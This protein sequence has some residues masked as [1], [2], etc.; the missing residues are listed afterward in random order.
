MH[1]WEMPERSF[2]AER[3]AVIF[4]IALFAVLASVLAWS[5]YQS[6]Q[7]AILRINE[8]VTTSSQIVA[9]N[10]GWI[11]AL[12]WQALRRIDDRLGPEVR[13]GAA[14][15]VEDIKDAVYG[16]P[17]QV[18]AYVVNPDGMTLY[19]TD[20]QLKPIDIRDREYFS[21]L[22]EGASEYISPLLV[23]RLNG[24]QIFVF[25][26]RLQRGGKFAGAA[27]VSFSADML[28]SIWELLDLGPGST[29]SIMRADGQLVARYPKPPGPIDLSQYI[30]FTD[31]LKKSDQGVYEAISPADGARRIVSYR[32]V[33]GTDLVVQ[34]SAGFEENMREFWRNLYF[35]VS[36]AAATAIGL[37][38]GAA[39]IASLLKRDAVRSRALERAL[40][41]NQMLM[42]E[43]HHRV[44]NNLQII[45]SLIRLQP[46]PDGVK[47]GLFDRLSAMSSVHEHIY[48]YDRF[49]EISAD[50]LIPGV[51][52]PLI[53]AYRPDVTVDYDLDACPVSNDQATS[54]ALLVGE[55]TTNALKY[56]FADGE[57]GK[58]EVRLKA[59]DG[60][61]ARL[62]IDDNGPGF[63]PDASPS[64]MGTRLIVASVQQLSGQH[65]YEI[66]NGTRFRADLRLI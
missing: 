39:W 32:R 52:D 13:T 48:R 56:A 26:R 31:Y 8:R 53:R 38:V 10:A 34:A 27:M 9:T 50:A 46:L 5:L 37:A 47:N 6:Y 54:L 66:D 17:G 29:V 28:S 59:L 25:S 64:G 18:Q 22:A 60:G 51:I 12:A 45:Q 49:S 33:P 3:A 62:E 16:L 43:I 24:E 21:A 20:P 7:A 15:G 30:L 63:S 55:V 61:R 40:D 44:K 23:S 58:L 41:Q 1:G 42:R 35:T 65:H 2:S 11:D 19:S 14:T 36:F 57:A 4:V